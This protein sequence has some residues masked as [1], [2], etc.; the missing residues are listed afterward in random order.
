[1][2]TSVSLKVDL[3]GIERK[4]S[5]QALDKGKLATVSYTHLTMQTNREV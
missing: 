5:P 4:V 3:K 1:M 2:G